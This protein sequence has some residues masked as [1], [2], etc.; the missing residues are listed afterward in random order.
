MS[1]GVFAPEDRSWGCYLAPDLIMP[2][3]WGEQVSADELGK[4]QILRHSDLRNCCYARNVIAAARLPHVPWRWRI[5]SCVAR[6]VQ[7]GILAVK[8][9]KDSAGPA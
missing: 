1:N 2:H 6:A 5:R 9:R 7:I 8:G 4:P 3:R